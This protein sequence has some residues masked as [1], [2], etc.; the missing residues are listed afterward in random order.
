MSTAQ[1]ESEV[2]QEDGTVEQFDVAIIGSGFAGLGM[3]IRLKDAGIEDFVVLERAA[4]LGGTWRDNHYPGCCCDIPSHVYSF[5]FELNPR[6]TRGF[7]AQPEI[8]D[9]LQRTAER[10]GLLPHVRFAHEVTAAAWD[11][12]ARRWTVE[13]TG[14][15]FSAR[16]LVAGAGPLSDPTVPDIPGLTEFR[17][18][19]FHSARWDHDHELDGERVAVIGTGA[20]AIQFVPAIQPRVKQL[21]LFQRTAPWVMPRLDHRITGVE[22]FL[23]RFFPFA[24]RIVRATL[25]WLMEMRVVG[26][27]KPALMRGADRI[28]RWHLR[29]QVADP[30]LRAKLT[31]GYVMGCKRILIADD[32]YPALVKPNVEVVTDGVREVRAHSVVDGDGTERAVDTIIFGTGFH[33]ADPPIAQRIRGRDGRTLA[34]HWGA[35]M[36]AYLGTTVAGFPN[37]FFML[38]PNT[39]LGHNSMVFMIESQLNYVLDCLRVMGERGAHAVEVRRAVQDAYNDELQAAM[40]GTVWTAGRCKSWYLD[41]TGRNTT[42]WPH[43]SFRFRRR[44]RR[45]DPDSY[46]LEP[47]RRP[48]PVAA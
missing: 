41:D 30:Q 15:S 20:S 37:L 35:G 7:A 26:F 17:G 48:E 2:G 8:R 6:W 33:V 40:R 42:L 14:G 21:H 47:A 34:E 3:A 31:P 38:G 16:V 29:R 22:H 4:Q 1:V 11:E 19:L 44:T 27:R 23:L 18:K 46:V 10:R 32:Y 5:S 43:A 36:T 28:A 9:Y 45:F 24:P 39:G 13:T 25:Y 12:D